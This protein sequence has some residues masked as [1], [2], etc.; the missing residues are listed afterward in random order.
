MMRA[1]VAVVLIGMEPLRASASGA[2]TS[3]ELI[4]AAGASRERARERDDL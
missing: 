3:A 2:W 1:G 4:A